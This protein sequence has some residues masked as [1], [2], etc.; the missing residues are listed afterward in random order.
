[1][2]KGEIEIKVR[3]Y[4]LDIYAH[5]NNAR[6]VEFL[7]EAR[8]ALFDDSEVGKD[9]ISRGFAFTVVNINVSYL[10]EARVNDLLSIVTDMKKIGNKSITLSQKIFRKTDMKQVVDAEVTFVLVNIKTGK[11]VVIDDE[12]K[13]IISKV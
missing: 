3:G 8:W 10:S 5:V 6:Y 9:M 2:M 13:S 12:I 11:A 1:M 4:H 7:E